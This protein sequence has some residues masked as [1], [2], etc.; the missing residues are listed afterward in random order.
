MPLLVAALTLTGSVAGTA[1]IWRLIAQSGPMAKLVLLILLVFSLISWGII[2]DKLLLLRRMD[3]ATE[4]FVKEFRRQETLEGAFNK[5]IKLKPSPV[6]TIFQAGYRAFLQVE[7]R[8]PRGVPGQDTLERIRRMSQQVAREINES[9]NTEAMRLDRR[10]A[11]LATTAS[12]SPFIGLFGTVWGIMNAFRGIGEAGS[13]SLAVVAPGIAEALVNTAAGLAAAI[14][15][16]IGYNYLNG[17]IQRQTTIME[18]FS[19][20]LL[21]ILENL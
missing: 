2:L 17:R 11:F 10:M 1:E 3:R 5:A 9:I 4:A 18:R 20:Q 16:L 19:A 14:P 21:N 13:A 8:W 12:A 15:A 6:N 7:E